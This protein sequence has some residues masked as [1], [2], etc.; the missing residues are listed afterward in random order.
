MPTAHRPPTLECVKA[1]KV[2]RAGVAPGDLLQVQVVQ[3]VLGAA[4]LRHVHD[5]VPGVKG[6][7]LVCVCVC[8]VSTRVHAFGSTRARRRPAAQQQRATRPPRRAPP[9]VRDLCA[10]HPQ[11]VLWV[12]VHDHVLRLRRAHHVVAQ[13]L[14]LVCVRLGAQ[15]RRLGLRIPSRRRRW[16]A[17]A[18]QGARVRMS[19]IHQAAG[20]RSRG[21]H[22][23][24]P[25]RRHAP[26]HALVVQEAA[27]VMRPG[28]AA[29]LDVLQQV[30]G[31][32]GGAISADAQHLA[33]SGRRACMRA[34]Q[35]PAVRLGRPG[36]LRPPPLCGAAATTV[37]LQTHAHAHTCTC[38]LPSRR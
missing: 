13:L 32:A 14:V 20:G 31:G 24:P 22:T 27:P 7:A 35:Q 15:V 3:L 29:E 16:C 23:A 5:H 11:R 21:T 38:T 10:E 17:R 6:R 1:G 30:G 26:A 8:T 9:V 4:A 19:W 36:W 34:P 2:E 28:Q 18:G 25:P 12:G 33:R 37:P